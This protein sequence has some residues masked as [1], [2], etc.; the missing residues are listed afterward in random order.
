V[1]TK[2]LSANELCVSWW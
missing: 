1:Q 2:L